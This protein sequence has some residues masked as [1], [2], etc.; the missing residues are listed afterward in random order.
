[1][2]IRRTIPVYIG[3]T[4]LCIM[5]VAYGV[6]HVVMFRSFAQVERHDAERTLA[7]ALAVLDAELAELDALTADWAKWN[8]CYD[9]VGGAAPDFV[10]RN[11]L[12]ETFRTLRID[13]IV[14]MDLDGEIIE[15]R[16]F[17]PVRD[18]GAPLRQDL[19][20]FLHGGSR[21][22]LQQ[23]GDGASRGVRGLLS[24]SGGEMLIASWPV[25][26][27]SGAGPPR[28][29]L[30]M[31]RQ[32]SGSSL[33]SL[34]EKA[35]AQLRIRPA[36]D[37]DL[38]DELN[39]ARDLVSSRSRLVLPLD[40]A[41]M[42][43]YAAVPDL[44]GGS[45]LVLSVAM[46]RTVH[47][48]AKRSLWYL[49]TALGIAGVVF[50]VVSILLSERLVLT[51][52]A[53]LARAVRSLGSDGPAS[54]L[55]VEG[56]DELA[57]LGTAIN[58]MLDAVQ[59]SQM[60]L[61]RSEERFRRMA[62]SIA[63]GLAIIEGTTTVYVNDRA[64]EIFGCPR[65]ELL[66]VSGLDLAAPEEHERLQIIIED[67]KRRGIYPDELEFWI[68]RKDGTRRCVHNRY[69]LSRVGET[70]AG[71]FV[72]TTDITERKIAEQALERLKDFNERIVQT[73]AEGIVVENDA[74]IST[75]VNPTAAAMLGYD[76]GDLVGHPW[77]EVI[78]A[79]QWAIVEDANR[80]RRGGESDRYELGVV[81]K[82]GRRIQILVS[83]C[84]MM[85]NGKFAGT[86]AV[87]SDITSRKREEQE[88][89]LLLQHTRQ[90]AAQ[91]SRIM[92]TVPEG[93]VVTDE[94]LH[95]VQANRTAEEYLSVL[96]EPATD[97]VGHLGGV[98]IADLVATESA[99]RWHE[100]RPPNSERVF[101]LTTRPLDT[102]GWV[103]VIREVT[104]EFLARMRVQDAERM[105]AV[106]QV[107]AGIAHDFNNILS[108]VIGH[109]QLLLRDRSLPPTVADRVH[110]ISE[111]GH[112]AARLVGQLLDY[113]RES[114][115][116]RSPV[117]L[118]VLVRDAATMLGR[119]IPASVRLSVSPVTGT[120][121]VVGNA[122]Q[123]QRVIANLAHNACDAMPSGGD[124]RISMTTCHL[125][126]G[127]L[128]LPQMAPGDWAVLRV[129][130]TGSGIPPE[131]IPR[132]FQ[133]FFTT[134]EI[135]K[136]TGLGLAQAHG[137]VRQH[138]GFID[139]ATHVGSGTTFT[140]YLPLMH[141]D[142]S[143]A[144]RTGEPG[145]PRSGKAILLVEDEPAVLDVS[146]AMLEELGFRVLPASSGDEA[147]ELHGRHAADIALVLTDLMMPGMDGATLVERLAERDP[148][149]RVLVL[150]GFPPD[151]S[152]RR[153]LTP[154][155]V[156][157]LQK[158]VVMERLLEAV[159]AA[160]GYG[161]S[162]EEGSANSSMRA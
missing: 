133:P 115:T 80:R 38:L 26:T 6:A 93:V 8:D 12:D 129:A 61:S 34:G 144:P 30:V 42:A 157:W 140:V 41:T 82:D 87:F 9:F 13:A 156:G 90:Q 121:R 161:I 24:L 65:E 21:A 3:L 23:R 135:G 128:P 72:V 51:R 55:P 108:S 57:D 76:P 15:A 77:H 114:L 40:D 99:A 141:G 92:N 7:R 4:L 120:C 97:S 96:R 69:S 70:V 122:A 117:D 123:L 153:R 110:G 100:V 18:T 127:D 62:D 22:A 14:F 31:C 83:G 66:A 130:D 32:L 105:A 106:G 91:I 50:A 125:S 147:L 119:T 113:A 104:E 138:Q 145:P 28:G 151:A 73:M 137:L 58:S 2:T 158:P 47:H 48:E 79:D 131:Y 134:K 1:M 49:M 10:Q 98:S 67:A 112:R 160:M 60:V 71:R 27:G 45:P 16:G 56:A 37:P 46:P 43:G 36:H 78:P 11:V 139:V 136:G 159:V 39:E 88:R 35:M 19:L 17:D 94:A 132:L 118:A 84:P 124:L 59:R 95:V 44:S 109:A 148:T 64:C 154:A 20:D 101:E 75:F 81:R 89:E 52:L 85:E 142:S 150:S 103:I 53:V 152:A 29:T 5:A 149:V 107:A 74:G 155:C 68:R 162:P 146:T 102:L 116:E 143:R 33:R 54:R 63:D 111:Q 126:P 25:L 86:I